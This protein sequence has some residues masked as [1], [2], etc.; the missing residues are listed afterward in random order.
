MVN[1]GTAAEGLIEV[2]DLSRDLGTRLTNVSC[3]LDMVQNQLIILGT[4]LIGGQV[5]VLVRNVGPELATYGIPA[6]DVL[7]DPKL[8]VYQGNTEVAANDDWELATRA[9]FAPTGAFDLTDG[10]KDSALRVVLNPG[11][12]TIHATGNAGSGIALVEVYE[13]P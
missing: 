8:V 9:Y 6:Q 10:S 3:R 7:P 1:T 11:G 5:P 12:Y 4:G 13:S 2:Y